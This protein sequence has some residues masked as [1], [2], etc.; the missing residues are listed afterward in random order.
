MEA[1]FYRDEQRNDSELGIIKVIYLLTKIRIQLGLRQSHPLF[2]SIQRLTV[3]PII[4]RDPGRW[5]LSPKMQEHRRRVF[6]GLCSLDYYRV[7]L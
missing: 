1:A 4:D 3:M 7:R 2:C 6:W 5:K